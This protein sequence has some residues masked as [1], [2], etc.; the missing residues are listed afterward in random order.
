MSINIIVAAMIVFACGFL[1]LW[2][3]S[4][5]L[6][7]KIESPKYKFLD[8]TRAFDEQVRKNSGNEKAEKGPTNES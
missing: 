8:M 6:R 7:K 2:L 5:R 3:S 4:P 1:C